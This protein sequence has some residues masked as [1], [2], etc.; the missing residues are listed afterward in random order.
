MD[1]MNLD[2]MQKQAALTQA[3]EFLKLVEKW[4]EQ[5]EGVKATI[6]EGEVK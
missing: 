1:V 5:F 2:D 6:E 4:G 3:E